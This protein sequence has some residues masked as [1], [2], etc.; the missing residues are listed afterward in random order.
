MNYSRI[1]SDNVKA[2]LRLHHM[3]IRQLAEEISISA[4]TLT[5]S[6]KSKKG[7]SIDA[8][9]SIADYFGLSINALCVPNLLDQGHG[10]MTVDL[11]KALSQYQELDDHGQQLVDLVFQKELERCRSTAAIHESAKPLN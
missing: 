2:L 3:S 8:L 11:G 5:D 1:T 7:V 9:M 6:L 4:S 10:I